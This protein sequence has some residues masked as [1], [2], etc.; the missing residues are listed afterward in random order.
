MGGVEATAGRGAVGGRSGA[1]VGG[2][3]QGSR[4]R[5]RCW[6]WRA[7]VAASWMCPGRGPGCVWGLLGRLCGVRLGPGADSEQAGSPAGAE[8]WPRDRQGIR[9]FPVWRRLHGTE[10]WR[11]GSP[12]PHLS[13]MA[14]SGEVMFESHL[15]GKQP[16]RRRV[17][18][19]L[20]EE[21]QET[22]ICV[23]FIIFPFAFSHCQKLRPV[24]N[25]LG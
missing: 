6:T 18:S 10:T 14:S 21:D 11:Q 15:V 2:R 23:L 3:G 16:G 1:G 7:G 8:S 20:C 4:V 19:L 17:P 25:R 24:R 22:H 9:R 5:V 13:G 12:L